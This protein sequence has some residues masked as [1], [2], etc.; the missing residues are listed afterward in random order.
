MVQNQYIRSDEITQLKNCFQENIELYS[1]Y[2]TDECVAGVI[3]YHTENV[4][5]VQYIS[6]NELGKEISALDF[7]FDYLINQGY[8]K[9]HLF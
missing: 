5:H 9:H 4:A 8:Y 7:L 3:V 6:A 2:M 1:V